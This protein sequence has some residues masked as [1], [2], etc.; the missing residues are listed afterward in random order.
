ML[1]DMNKITAYF[2]DVHSELVTKTSWPT[3]SELTNSS[4]VVMIA[5]AIIALVVFAMDGSFGWLLDHIYKF[6]Y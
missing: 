1:N 5:S 2:K 6:L 4:V 3:W